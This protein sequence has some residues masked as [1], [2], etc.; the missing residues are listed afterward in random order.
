MPII[1]MQRRIREVGR[2]RLG[3]QGVKD[4]RSYP[5]KINR[6]RMTSAD[7][8][9]IEAVAERYGGTARG[10]DNNGSEQFEVITDAAEVPIL[11]PPNP[12]DLGFSQFFESWAKG[13]CTKR[14]DGLRDA[15]RDLPCDCDP[16]DRECKATTRL[17]VILPEI[18]GLG[19]WRLESHGYY[20][21]VELAAAVEM[22]EALVGVR[23][24]VPARLRLDQ[25]EIRRLIEGKAVV[26]KIVV[27]AIDL[28]VSVSQVQAVTAGN[29]SVGAIATPTETP[30]EIGQPRFKPVAALPPADAPALSIEEQLAEHDNAPPKPKR[31]NSRAPLPST[32]RKPRSAAER[33]A[34]QPATTPTEVCSLCGEPYAGKNVVP[35]RERWPN[36]EGVISRFVHSE[37]AEAERKAEKADLL[38]GE[39]DPDDTPSAASVIADT[40][41]G[42][43]VSQAELDAARDREF[44]DPPSSASEAIN[45]P[46]P[47]VT[48][49]PRM[50]THKMHKQ[51]FALLAEVFPI[52]PNTPDANEARR[53]TESALCA[54]LGTPG[55]ESHKDITFDL[56]RLLIDALVGLQEGSLIWRVDA[57]AGEGQLLR[58]E[59][60]EP[61]TM[62][63]NGDVE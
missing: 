16:E 11:L 4:G 18:A 5:K 57:D 22:I 45:S 61:I 21:A 8:T 25:R 26:R 41:N 17:S 36:A 50:P 6:F 15:V 60:G 10:W 38:D 28:D 3:V 40:L 53:S 13:F 56:A 20:A 24:M 1:G 29:G 33:Q 47:L 55:I 27:P 14:C 58:A 7:R 54:A 9:I 34:G 44:S 43:P 48:D 31:A 39:P 23:S 59:T 35:N 62:T 49:G 32:G 63:P 51:I 12:T 30:T 19:V 42:V 46:P 2:L 37:C 52:P